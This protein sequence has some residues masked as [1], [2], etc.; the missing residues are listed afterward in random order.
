MKQYFYSFL[1]LTFMSASAFAQ[2]NGVI[3]GKVVDA[4]T[5]LSLPGATLRFNTG[6][7]YTVSTQTGEFEFLNVPAGRYEVS[8]NYLGYGPQTKTVTLTAGENAVLDFSLE[9]GGTELGEVVVMGDRLRGQAS[10]LN[11]QKNNANITNVISSDQVGRFPDANIG[12]ALKRVPGITMQND[13]GEARN[14]IVRGL[15]PS[16]NS[17]TLNGDRIPSAEGDNRNVQMDLIPA[18]MIQTI[19]VNKTL[20]PDMDADAIGGSVNLIT[21]ATPHGQRIS[22]TLGGGYN[23]IRGKAAYTGAFVYGNRFASDRI[24]MVLSGSYN[25]NDYGSDNVEAVW[26]KDDFGNVYIE[27][28]DIR[29][30]DVRRARRSIAA[31]FDFQ[32]SPSHSLYL[33]GMYNWRDDWENRFRWNA[34]DIEPLY[35]GNNNITGYQG[36]MSLETKGG[37]DNNRVKQRRLEEQRV[38]NYSIGGNHLFGAAVDM[39]WSA[40]FARASEYRPH[41]RYIEYEIPYDADEP[42]EPG[43]A[44]NRDFG[45]SRQP[46]LTFVNTPGLAD[47]DFDKVT[48]QHEKTVEEEFGAKLNFRVPLS[49]VSGQKGRL[50][51]GARLR[52]KSKDRNNVFYEYTPIGGINFGLDQIAVNDLRGMHWNPSD[53]YAIG[54]LPSR[55]FVGGLPLSDASQFEQ[56]AD[57]AEFLAANYHAKERIVAGYLRWDQDLSTRLSMIVGARVERTGISYTG[58]ILQDEEEL[59]G[60]REVENSYVNVLPN[61]S[62]KYNA[63][64]DLV[65]HAAFTTGIARPNYYALAPYVDSRP[66]D[67]ELFAGNPNLSASYAW[68]FDLMGEYYFQSVGLISGGA[69]YKSINDFIYSQRDEQYTTAKFARD[70]GNLSNPIPTGEN[71]TF[72]Q[73]QN[74]DNVQVYGFEVAVQRQLDFFT[75]NFLKGFGV[76]VNYTFTESEAK[77]ITNEDGEVRTGLSLPGTAPH[78]FNASLSWENTR[79][80]ARLSL[81]YAAAYLD[82]LGG[83]DF[84]DRYYDQQTFLDANAAYRITKGLRVFAEA[85]NLTNQPLR[86]YQGLASRTMQMEYYQPRYNLGVKLDL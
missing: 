54:I 52:L 51:F 48:E 72:V 68:N 13:Q 37:I 58:N 21:R 81:N 31:A 17:V 77:G 7:R 78:M 71:W 47:Y 29:K 73:A 64:S 20:T 67:G 69:F 59:D 26:A 84:E 70:F 2:Q 23:P 18:D 25:D 85:N 86:Y 34:K 10:A 53:K 43:V 27:E 76:Y 3:S 82:E 46:L 65:L 44:F 1:L 35:D 24:G 8:I 56:E 19:V 9:A 15:A 80:S 30:Y 60:T 66:S 39:D 28:Q 74:G 61:L 83:N 79:F 6:N 33:N 14:I 5:Q 36:A 49:V 32:L 57:P 16:L 55:D 38:Q 42:D 12:D 75:S 45:P 4:S 62:F 22:A 41:E 11:Q 50:R 40:N 63:T